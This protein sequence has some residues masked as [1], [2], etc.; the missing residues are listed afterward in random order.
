MT[1]LDLRDLELSAPAFD[2]VAKQYEQLTTRLRQ[3]TTRPQAVAVVQEWDRLLRELETWSNLVHLRFEQD[4]ANEAY[5]AA[6]QERDRLWPKFTELA[7]DFKRALLEGPRRDDIEQQFGTCAAGL[8]EAHV[9]SYDPQIEQEVVRES[10]LEAEYTELLAAARLSFQD[11]VYN[12]STIVK[13]REDPDRD[14]R[15]GAEQARWGWFAQQREKLDRIYDDLVGLRTTMA[16]KL[17]FETFVGL[18]YKRMVRVDYGRE[19]V[20]R[21]REAVRTHV[22]PLAEELNRRRAEQ[23]GVDRLMSWDEGIFDPRGN[24]RPRGDHDWMIGQAQ[25]MF[26]SLADELDAFFR[27][28]RDSHLLDLKSRENKAGGGF[29]TSLD[30]YG[31]PVIFANFNGTKG[32]VEVFT[33]EMGH[34]FQNYLSRT[35]PLLDYT[36]PTHES[37]E[38]HSMSLEFLTWPQMD[39]FFGEEAER[40]R[41]I[42]LMQ[43]LLF[44]PYGVAVDHFQ[45]QVYEN[46]EA[47]PEQRHA[48][49]REMEQRYLP[50]RDYGDLEHPAAG[51]L[52]Q[53]QRHIYLSPFYYI[54]YTLALC[55]ALQFW[56]RSRQDPQ[57]ALR[58]YIALCERGGSLPFRQL[59]DSA[60]LASPFEPDCLRGAVEQ[61]R[62]YLQLQ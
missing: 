10:D 40:F 25:Q 39:R 48:M 60:G 18:G 5:R 16:R 49:W 3:A 53:S 19:E 34:A 28:M 35:Q 12:L 45:H 54:D 22:T 24:P 11:E 31:L 44:L 38:I 1:T 7:I 13:F 43:S 21:Y 26:G 36:W 29:C 47:T 23:L 8:W 15:H 20:E 2:A 14:V 9:T 42:H 30:R 52:W 51:G 62:Q 50:W 56:V 59:V 6:R 57:G 58:D 17:G 46:P 55:C 37:C 61:A 32:D 33:H 27:L 41:R 4:T